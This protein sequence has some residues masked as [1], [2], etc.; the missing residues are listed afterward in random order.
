MSLAK[1]YRVEKSRK[2]FVCGKCGD[3]IEVGQPNVSF[4]VGFRGR[5]Q[6][7]CGK[8]ACYPS[9][10]E[11][12]SSLVASVYAA[13]ED[14]DVNTCDDLEDLTSAVQDVIDAANEC[15][16]EYENS[17]MFERNEDLQERYDLLT[18]AASQLEMWA[19]NLVDEPQSDEYSADAHFRKDHD[20][21][22]QEAREAA[23]SAVNEMELP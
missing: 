13:Q 11:R 12:E 3:T 18:E 15:A 17:E 21:W 5:S 9:S 1:V 8:P 20:E 7:R 6:R 10:S 2:S 16:S 4:A 23:T 22:I 14:F 19:D